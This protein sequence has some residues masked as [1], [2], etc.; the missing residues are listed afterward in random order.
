MACESNGKSL[1]THAL[2]STKHD[3][4]WQT[5]FPDHLQQA[6]THLF[7]SYYFTEPH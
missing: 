1:L 6:L 3:G 4:M 7:L 2:R 5:F